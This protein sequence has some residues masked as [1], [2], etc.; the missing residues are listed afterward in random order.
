MRNIILASIITYSISAV[1]A[2][3]CSDEI[4]ESSPN[5]KKISENT[6]IGLTRSIEDQQQ[7]TLTFQ[8]AGIMTPIFESLDIRV[9]EDEILN[10]FQQY[11]V[12]MNRKP[13]HSELV[14]GCGNLPAHNH[15]ICVHF[16]DN[17][18]ETAAAY[19]KKHQHLHQDTLDLDYARNPTYV[20]D[21]HSL[22]P[23]VFQ[24][25][26]YQKICTEGVMILP[27]DYVP[28]YYS[29]LENDITKQTKSL[30]AMKA[31]IGLLADDGIYETYLQKEYTKAQ[32]VELYNDLSSSQINFVNY[33]EQFNNELDVIPCTS[34]EEFIKKYNVS[35]ERIV[36]ESG[37][38]EE[39]FTNVIMDEGWEN[40]E[41]FTLP[42][43]FKMKL[44]GSTP[45]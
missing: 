4:K 1:S 45:Q 22:N 19:R 23:A 6:Y 25:F 16:I 42:K 20:A 18:G 38:T 21:L 12:I 26:R 30:T 15:Q 10:A 43:D 3:D 28:S 29:F 33:L 13:Q 35:K 8:R 9:S 17:Y 27:V 5:F 39:Q 31:V 24:G 34:L 41:F 37:L 7:S 36:R 14:I 2:M 32:L 40:F 11:G 44:Y